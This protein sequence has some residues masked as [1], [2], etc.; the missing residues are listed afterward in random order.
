MRSIVVLPA[1]LGPST[2]KIWPRRTSRS[3]P[4]TARM[5]PK[6]LTRPV[7]LTARSAMSRFVELFMGKNA[8][9]RFQGGFTPVSRSPEARESRFAD[10]CSGSV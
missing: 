10:S 5:S 7:A 6:S 8:G 9:P 2:P 3:M 1:P 4:S